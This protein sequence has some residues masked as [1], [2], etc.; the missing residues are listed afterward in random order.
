[1]MKNA[2]IPAP[3]AEAST[4][5]AIPTF[6]LV[7]GLEALCKSPV[8]REFSSR[9]ETSVAMFTSPLLVRLTDMRVREVDEAV[10]DVV[11]R[12]VAA[13]GCGLPEAPSGGSYVLRPE[14]PSGEPF[15]LTVP[16][17][18]DKSAFGDL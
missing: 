12:V 5:S 17:M 7:E 11:V 8:G 6:A 2:R 1:M 3:T 10:L 15:P 18:S 16:T 4:A 13:P 14:L 9:E